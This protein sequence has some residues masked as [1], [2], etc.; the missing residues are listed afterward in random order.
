M[1]AYQSIGRQTSNENFENQSSRARPNR[2]VLPAAVR[3]LECVG[4]T[5]GRIGWTNLNHATKLCAGGAS[6]GAEA[7]P[8]AREPDARRPGLPLLPMEIGETPRP[9]S[10]QQPAA[11]YRPRNRRA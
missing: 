7:A 5:T 8:A 3:L 6:R 4:Q 10:L 11:V 9:C 2:L 1:I